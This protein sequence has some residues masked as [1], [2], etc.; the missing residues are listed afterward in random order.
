MQIINQLGGGF[1]KERSKL[2]NEQ[3][4][5]PIDEVVAPKETEAEVE[6]PTES[7]PES[8]VEPESEVASEQPEEDRVPKSRFLTMHQRAIEAEKA[9][10]QFEAERENALEPARPVADD[11]DLKKFYVETFGDTPLSEKLYQAELA[12]LSAIEER[13]TERAFER[14]TER[15]QI[16]AQ[17][18]DSRVESMDLAF[19]ELSVTTGKDLTDD[20]QVA[21][22]DIVEKYSP[23]DRNGKIPEE[24]LL[25]L[26]QAY[27]IYQLQAE[28]SK[29]S[30]KERN[31]VAALAST[32]SQGTPD[33]S[34]DANWRPGQRGRWENKLPR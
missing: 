34:S 23:K 17:T 8:P 16:E 10:R 24:Y 12:R 5:R 19:E 6:E 2:T 29:P 32:R 13:A 22:L 7:V 27:E 28:T 21:I 11:A 25:P 15:E 14:L 1:E 20:E 30:R 4:D 18:I 31:S 3:L 33:T 26:D 9:L